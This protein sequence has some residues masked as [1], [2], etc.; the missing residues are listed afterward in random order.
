ME[1]VWWWLFVLSLC[2][3]P[4]SPPR[5]SRRVE[6]E[7]ETVTDDGYYA[8]SRTRVPG[9]WLVRGGGLVFVADSSPGE[10][11][12]GH[13]S[14][15]KKQRRELRKALEKVGLLVRKTANVGV[16]TDPLPWANPWPWFDPKRPIN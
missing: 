16:S 1:R 15:I 7:W 2:G 12:V 5:E 9:G 3:C 13:Q 10:A 11:V 4:P 14:R 8:V 6:A